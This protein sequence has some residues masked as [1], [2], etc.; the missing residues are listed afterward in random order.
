MG[1]D[2]RTTLH[3]E[4]W[5]RGPNALQG[6]IKGL[7]FTYG[8]GGEAIMHYSDSYAFRALG[9]AILHFLVEIKGLHCTFRAGGEAIMQYMIPVQKYFFSN[10]K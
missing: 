3:L 2:K 8:A 10:S 9:G 1:T 4:G 5:R 7:Y 6:Q